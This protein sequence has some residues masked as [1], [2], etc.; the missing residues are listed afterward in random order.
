MHFQVVGTAGNKLNPAPNG[1]LQILE[2]HQHDL[3]PLVNLQL[4]KLLRAAGILI[5]PQYVQDNGGIGGA[6]APDQQFHEGR[7]PIDDLLP[8][9]HTLEQILFSFLLV[10]V[11][12]NVQIIWHKIVDF[13]IA[14]A[15]IPFLEH[16]VNV[17]HHPLQLL[18]RVGE[19]QVLV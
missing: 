2:C 9:A 17:Y 4:R 1:D 8:L 16:F 19:F 7:E 12:H 18:G 14:V 11:D 15:G 10:L 3:L 5:G 6:E 13:V